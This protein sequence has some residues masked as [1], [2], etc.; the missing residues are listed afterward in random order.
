DPE[1]FEKDFGKTI[2]EFAQLLVTLDYKRELFRAKTVSIERR[3]THAVNYTKGGAIL[4]IEFDDV[5]PK[6]SKAVEGTVIFI[7]KKVDITRL[8][9]IHISPQ[10]KHA[11]KRIRDAY[12]KYNPTYFYLL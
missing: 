3:L 1:E 8:K 2:E 4:G 11:E 7:P 10:A 12:A 6:E 5:L 9:E